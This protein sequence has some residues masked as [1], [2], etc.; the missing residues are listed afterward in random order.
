VKLESVDTIYHDGGHNAFTSIKRWKGKYW[1]CFRNDTAHRSLNGKILV[2]SSPDLKTWSN[3]SVA[4]DTAADNRDPKLFVL[5]DKL[6]V[7]SDAVEWGDKE[8]KTFEDIYTLLSFTEDG[9]HWNTPRRVWKPLGVIWWVEEVND[10][11]YGA[12]YLTNIKKGV[13]SKIRAEFFVSDDGFEWKT[14]S[15]I[16]QERQASECALAFLPDKRAVAFV[17]HDDRTIIPEIK[18]ASPPYTSW[19]KILDFPFVTNGPCL[20]LVNNTL[21]ASSRAFLDWPQP[22][23]ILSLAE[24]GAVRGLLIMTID[25]ERAEVVPELVISC[26][27]APEGDWPDVSYAGIIDLGAGRFAMSYY[28]GT[29]KGPTDIKIAHLKL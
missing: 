25:I 8:T 11:V 1:V 22:E 16:S 18:V 29:K 13:L 23:E 5:H 27:P 21:V 20:G 6:Y 2:I 7:T 24:P 28:S 19:E 10:R 9:T 26:P 4:I 14:L 12:G 3:P 17:R 15:V